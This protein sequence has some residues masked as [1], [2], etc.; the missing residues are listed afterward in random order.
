MPANFSLIGHASVSVCRLPAGTTSVWG[1]ASDQGGTWTNCPSRAAKINFA[2]IDLHTSLE[3]VN[4]LPITTWNCHVDGLSVRLIGPTAQ[5]FAAV[6]PIGI[7][8]RR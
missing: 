2:A 8:D 6:F 1:D 3:A 4:A 5:D 7:N